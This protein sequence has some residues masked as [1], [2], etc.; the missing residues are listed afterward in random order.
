[1]AGEKLGEEKKKPGAKAQMLARFATSL[2]AG[3]AA[4][5]Q[6][7]ADLG[8]GGAG[9]ASAFDTGIT[10]LKDFTEKLDAATSAE[11][12]KLGFSSIDQSI[13]GEVAKNNSLQ[14]A[15]DFSLGM[16]AGQAMSG[17]DPEVDSSK[18]FDGK[19]EF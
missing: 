18:L 6:R 1:M 17:K 15:L 11:L 19:L 14:S 13:K 10:G 5:G 7:R 3:L 4:E 8:Y 16:K 2:S 9:F 12:D